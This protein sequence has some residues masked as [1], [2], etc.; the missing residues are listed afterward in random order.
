MPL[1]L[2]ALTLAAFAIGTTEF[3]I[4]GLI[5]TIAADLGVSL[6]SAGLLV[7]LCALG[8]AIGAPILNALTGLAQA[9][10]IAAVVT[11]AALGLTALSGRL[12]R[13]AASPGPA[14]A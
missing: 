5:P 9:P 11:L 8:V 12:D 2:L 1:A 13:R 10:W 3:A 4:A 7:S 14:L 6:P